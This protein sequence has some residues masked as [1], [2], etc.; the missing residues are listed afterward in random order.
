MRN[1]KKLQIPFDMKELEKLVASFTIFEKIE[2][3]D[4]SKERIR[5]KL[6]DLRERQVPQRTVLMEMKDEDV[7]LYWFKN[8][9]HPDLKEF[10]PEPPKS[11]Q[12]CSNEVI[13]RDIRQRFIR[14]YENGQHNYDYTLEE[15]DEYVEE[16]KATF[17]VKLSYFKKSGKY[18]SYGNYYTNHKEMFE[19]FE[20][21]QQKTKSGKLPDLIEGYSDFVVLVEVPNHPNN[22]PALINL[23]EDL[24]GQ[25]EDELHL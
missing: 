5:I 10:C 1:L 4:I 23:P 17:E 18:Y 6:K 7:V 11:T 19:I 9:L 2:F 16:V 15:I 20:E 12:G 14:T 22:Y 13:Q 8:W 24:K 3:S 25:E 21:V